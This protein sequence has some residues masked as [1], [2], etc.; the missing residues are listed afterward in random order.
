MKNID[1]IKILKLIRPIHSEKL[2]RLGRQLDGGYVISE[3]S[4]EICDSLV[5]FGINNDWFFEL[6]FIK[7]KKNP[8]L[9][10]DDVFCETGNNVKLIKGFITSVVKFYN[11][12]VRKQ[13]VK[14]L[15]FSWPFLKAKFIEG[16]SIRYIKYFIS[17]NNNFSNITIEELFNKYS[18]FLSKNNRMLKIDI[19]GNEYDIINDLLKFENNISSLIIEFHDI[20]D[21]PSRFEIE[22]NKILNY[23]YIEHV[24]FNN[25]ATILND[26]CDTIELSFIHKKFCIGDVMLS[27]SKY[28]IAG[29]DFPNNCDKNDYDIMFN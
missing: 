5:S 12:E 7:I 19:E 14:D 2:I 9:M 3:K 22:L 15:R 25:Y 13:F 1:Y 16:N 23:Y 27:T 28:P 4:L 24:H 11:N 10:V 6:D 21:N 29:L 20:I 18:K 17:N 26:V 8:V